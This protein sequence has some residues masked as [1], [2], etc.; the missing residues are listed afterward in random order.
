MQA[1]EKEAFSRALDN[2]TTNFELSVDVVSTD[3]HLSIKKLMQIDNR[4]HHIEHQF[5]PWHIAKELLKKNMK[6]A[7]KKGKPS[8]YYH[9]S[10]IL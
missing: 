1:M 8:F 7:S 3:R 2:I 10:K 4:F 6:E 5:N 9:K